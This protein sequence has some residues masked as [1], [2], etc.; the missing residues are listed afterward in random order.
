MQSLLVSVGHAGDASAAAGAPPAAAP[1]NSALITESTD[2]TV[3]LGGIDLYLDV[4]LNGTHAG[5]VHFGYKDG[6]LWASRAS[7][8]TLGFTLPTDTPDPVRLQGLQGLQVKYDASGQTLTL[9]APLRLL[10]LGTTVLD[11]SNN[12]RPVATASPGI[13]LNYDLYGT[14]GLHGASNLSAFTELRAFNAAGVFSTTSLAQA[15]NDG[16]G[17]WH[18][19]S[20][21][22]D[23]SWS[24]S[25]PDDL[26]TL[27]LG[28]TLTDALSWS[29]STRIAG[30]Q[31]GTNFALQ[32]YLVTAPLP[33]F[34]GSATLPSDVQLYVNGLRQYSGQIPAGPFQL[35]TLPNINGAGNA[36]VVLTNAL[37]Q[38]T[39]LNFPLYGEHQLLREGFSDWS[40]EIGVVRENYGLDSF[41]YGHDAA[42]SGTWRYGFTNNFTAEAHAELTD[43]LSD[44]GVGG[45]WLLGGIGGV[46]SA[47]VA[48]SENAGQGGEQ[49]SLGYNW[50]NN[51]FNLG[52]NGTRTYGSYRDVATLYGSPTPDITAQAYVSYNFDRLGNLGVS[53]LDLDYP[54]QPATRYASA[55]WFKTVGRALSLNLSLN[56][57]LNNSSNRTIFLIATLSLDHN[58]TLSGGAQRE[59]DRTGLV[60]NASQ[61]LPSQGGFGWRASLSQ[62]DGQN[63]GQGELDYLGRY[64][65]LQA[66][67]YDVGDTRYGYASAMGSLVLMSGDVF[68]AR[69]IYDGFAVVSTDGI[70]GVPV[71][72]Q[73]NPV[74][75]TDSHG[76][77]LVT[78]LNSY[79]NNKVAIDAMNLP[80]DVSINRVDADVATTDRAGTLVKFGITPVRSA[81]IIL[82]DAAGKPLPIGSLVQLHGHTGEPAL[83]GFDGAVYLDTL[84]PRNVL[85]VDTPSGACHAS[86][87]Y[88]RHGDG[89]PQIG[90]LT[91][92][93]V[94]P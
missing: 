55:Y 80:A 84:E 59:G 28:D 77:L 51:R 90:P 19:Q 1:V 78:P 75:T 16:N 7:L 73:N 32:P 82:V 11:T 85:D 40:T 89:I 50:S 42:A 13:L 23:T 72:L 41:D 76:L 18:N 43:G 91:C 68:A 24:T 3:N 46:L 49:Y 33:S 38:T 15:T 4:T 62:G 9:I 81:S 74:G 39:T 48:H 25:F 52:I 63:G 57:D 69:Q 5:L 22:L 87:A 86:F 10:K 66:G 88:A 8:H 30:V 58:I 70:A 36:Q 61:A 53:Y 83:V 47:S 94:S 92:Q 34:I 79:Q 29:R 20:V 31:F 64:G 35:N 60:M 56:Q 26:L 37:G 45:N 14:Y 65:Q 21:R 44:A 2:S 71:N 12:T 67:V 6:E 17:N 54:Q 27:R 93:K